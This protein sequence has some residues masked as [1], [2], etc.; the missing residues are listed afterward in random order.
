MEK[1]QKA[2][3]NS[4]SKEKRMRKL[5]ERDRT[6]IKKRLIRVLSLLITAKGFILQL[7]KS[8]K[9]RRRKMS[10]SRMSWRKANGLK[11]KELRLF[12]RK[13]LNWMRK[14]ILPKLSTTK[15]N[16]KLKKKSKLLIQIV[17]LT[18]TL[19]LSHSIQLKLYLLRTLK[20]WTKLS[21]TLKIKSNTTWVIPKITS[22]R[23]LLRTSNTFRKQDTKN[24][25]IL[26]TQ[27]AEET[28]VSS[29]LKISH[30][31]DQIIESSISISYI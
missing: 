29:T 30:P 7:K 20:N 2:K 4:L 11:K 6:E 16:S 23:N 17:C 25:Q 5:K 13:S 10:T 8:K 31:F 27:K 28:R 26:R 3:T 22:N 24:L 15:R 21:R 18:T 9:E 12:S 19:W 14:T 1:L